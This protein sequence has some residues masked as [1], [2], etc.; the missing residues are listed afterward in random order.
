MPEY[1]KEE[2]ENFFVNLNHCI[3][4]YKYVQ[5]DGKLTE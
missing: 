4:G 5:E 2:R 3:D 1:T